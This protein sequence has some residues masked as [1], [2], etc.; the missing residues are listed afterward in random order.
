MVLG[1]VA[2]S[3]LLIGPAHKGFQALLVNG[4]SNIAVLRLMAEFGVLGI[5]AIW[6]AS[7]IAV[8]RERSEPS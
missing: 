5:T 4:Y 2:M 6:I 3:W 7:L 8:R 1:L